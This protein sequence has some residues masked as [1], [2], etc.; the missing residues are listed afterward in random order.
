[1][2][3]DD[4]NNTALMVSFQAGGGG[5]VGGGRPSQ[6]TTDFYHSL[7]GGSESTLAQVQTRIHRTIVFS[8]LR[9]YLDTTGASSVDVSHYDTVASTNLTVSFVTSADAAA[10]DTTGTESS[11]D[12]DDVSFFADYVSGSSQGL[13]SVQMD[14]DVEEQP[15]GGSG[16]ESWTTTTEYSSSI[17]HFFGS[18]ETSG[19]TKQAWRIGSESI[20]NLDVYASAFT[21]ATSAEVAARVNTTTSTNIVVAIT[22]TGLVSDTTGTESIVDADEVGVV[23]SASA[24]SGVTT[25]SHFI[26]MATAVDGVSSL[27]Y[28]REHPMQAHLLRR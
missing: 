17:E 4:G 7:F 25:T 23:R 20:G 3:N 8:N 14:T 1:M 2:H 18:A 15:R 26:E 16:N 13:T 19:S 22:G 27:V 12:G 10:E 24:V 21:S 5:V 28:P 9:A 11:V 6:T